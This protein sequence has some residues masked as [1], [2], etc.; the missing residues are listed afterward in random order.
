MNKQLITHIK[1]LYRTTCIISLKNNTGFVPIPKKIIKNGK[2]LLNY[3]E[4]L[5]KFIRQPE[6]AYLEKNI[7]KKRVADKYSFEFPENII[8]IKM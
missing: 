5:N 3:A 4:K 2:Q 6:L 7:I 8:R 1:N